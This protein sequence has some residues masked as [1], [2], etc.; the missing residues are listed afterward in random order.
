M[1]F[2]GSEPNLRIYYGDRVHYLMTKASASEIRPIMDAMAEVT[3]AM[4]KRVR[5]DLTGDEVASALQAFHLKGWDD[6][7]TN[8]HARLCG[9]F[10]KLAA[11]LGCQS[12]RDV[13]SMLAKAARVLLPVFKTAQTRNLDIG[14]RKAW[15]WY[16]QPAFRAHYAPKARWSDDADMLVGFYLSLKVNTT[17]LER[18]L[19]DLLTQLS[20]HSGPLSSDGSTV[21]SIMEINVKGPRSEEEFFYRAEGQDSGLLYPTEFGRLCAKLWLQHF[22][23]RFRYAYK[24]KGSANSPN[25]PRSKVHMKGSLA[26]ACSGRAKATARAAASASEKT[27]QESF[28]PGLALPLARTPQL[29]G[30]R[31]QSAGASASAAMANFHTHSQRKQD[32]CF[33]NRLNHFFLFITDPV[34]V[35]SLCCP[36]AFLYSALRT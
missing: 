28:V 8:T 18:D 9:Q 34:I 25:S 2:T 24:K 35:W 6:G 1:K 26:A 17:T 32:R 31:W 15:S 22:G 10:N 4:L 16:C 23:R 21:A 7:N 36:N 5:V 14:N 19:G 20:A 29:L 27:P 11:M 12:P 13:G 33:G 30:T 3:D